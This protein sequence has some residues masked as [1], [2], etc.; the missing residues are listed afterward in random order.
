[1]EPYARRVEDAVPVGIE[2]FMRDQRVFDW[3][4][5]QKLELCG[6]TA[7]EIEKSYEEVMRAAAFLSEHWFC[8]LP[9]TRAHMIGFFKS[10]A[11]APEE[12]E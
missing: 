8:L 10:E 4:L 9:T 12:I 6:E 5:Q 7:E 2:D 1:M 3:A 11:G